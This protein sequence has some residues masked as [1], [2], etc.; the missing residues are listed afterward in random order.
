[1]RSGSTVAQCTNCNR[2]LPS[3]AAYCAYCG[4]AIPRSSPTTAPQPQP[5]PGVPPASRP[6]WQLRGFYVVILLVAVAFSIGRMTATNAPRTPAEPAEELQTVRQHSESRPQLEGDRQQRTVAQQQPGQEPAQIEEPK[7]QETPQ[8]A[9]E[10]QP[11]SKVQEPAV[12]P[13][14][15]SETPAPLP[16]PQ[17]ALPPSYTNSIGMAFVL[18]P[19]GTFMMGSDHGAGDE[20]PV[21]EVHISTP[22]YLGKYEVTQ[23]QWQAVMGDNPSRFTGNPERPVE[24]VS[25][26]DAQEFVKRLNS[27]EDGTRYRLPT[28][29]EWE[30]AARAGTTT[31]YS[32][33]NAASKLGAYAWYGANAGGSTHPVGQKPPNPWGL[34][35]IYGNVWE[36]VQDWYG[37]YTAATAVDP[38]GPSSGSNRVNRGG[39]WIFDARLCRS[40]Y[41]RYWPPGNRHG[42]LGLRLL[43]TVE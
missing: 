31:T 12:S 26:H 8:V 25:W 16:Q 43:R 3:H 32:F 38:A 39:S 14:E 35:D 37:P 41:R 34:Y 2:T 29:A 36:W 27:K 30:Y 13:Q 22:F 40:A 42:I 33:G 21:H 4:T 24:Q 11:D 10:G 23:G 5:P 19:S 17:A 15:A 1:M 28:E 7:A 18:I 6:F 20:R 9:S